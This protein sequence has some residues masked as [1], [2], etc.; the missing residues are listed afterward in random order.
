MPLYIESKSVWPKQM[1]EKG[2]EETGEDIYV[3]GSTLKLDFGAMAYQLISVN[4]MP[5]IP[6]LPKHAFKYVTLTLIPEAFM[7]TE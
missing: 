1:R 5:D 3:Q 4:Q 7:K 2:H 6:E